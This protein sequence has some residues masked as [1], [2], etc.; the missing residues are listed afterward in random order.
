M[1]NIEILEEIGPEPVSLE[2]AKVYCRIDADYTGDDDLLN[3]LITSA[4][5]HIEMWANISL[6]EKRIKVYSD[7][8]DTLWL[9]RSPVREIESVTD[10]EGN[11]IPYN[12][13]VTFKIKLSHYGGYF[14]TYKAGFEPLPKDLKI[15]V[16]KQVL[17]DYDNRE[18]LVINGNN[19]VLS[20][21]TL[22]NATK[23]LVKPYNKNLWL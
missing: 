16:L 20:S 4:R 23:N 9:P 6:I 7:T 21:T 11:A 22:S 3:E 14:V 8:K 12:S 15:A 19:Q 18:N 10:E 1:L 5:T 17:T 13:A 2:E